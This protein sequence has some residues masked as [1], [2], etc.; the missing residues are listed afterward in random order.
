MAPEAIVQTL[1]AHN[2]RVLEA[3][4]V[5][6]V[7]P[8]LHK[9]TF[10]VEDQVDFVIAP[11]A[12]ASERA[13]AVADDLRVDMVQCQKSRDA[14]G[15]PTVWIP[16]TPDLT[17]K[18]VMIVDD[19]IDGGRTFVDLAQK[20][21][22]I[23]AASVILRATHSI[24]SN[25]IAV[26]DQHIDRIITTDSCRASWEERGLNIENYPQITVKNWKTSF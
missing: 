4:N 26:F 9:M 2:P 14:S 15:S 19:I 16:P 12:G 5:I 13:R 25:G 7:I 21:K 22:T 24:F 23:G 18:R 8:T 10:A 11:D 3:F 1:D 17:G 20:L 6:N